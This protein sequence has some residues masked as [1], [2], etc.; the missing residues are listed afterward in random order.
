M[1]SARP[2]AATV[3][4][5]DQ[6]LEQTSVI[7]PTYNRAAFLVEALDSLFAQTLSPGEI[8]VI[9]DGST[10]DTQARLRAFGERIRYARKEN[11][12]KSDSLNIGLEMARHPLIWIMDDDDL[13]LP[14]TLERLTT[15]LA[16]RPAA[17]IAYGRYQRFRVDAKT[18]RRTFEDCGY[19]PD[20]A[21]KDLFLAT[22]EDFFVHH[23]GMLV[24]KSAYQAV[25][26]FSSAY[27]SE[28]YE[29][30]IRLARGH[31]S[32]Q[33][34]GPVFLQRQHDGVRAGGLAADR[35]MKRWVDE[36]A[37]LFR[38][39]RAALPLAA[40]APEA[41]EPLSPAATREALIRRGV[42]MARK[43]LWSEAHAD[44]TAA[45]NVADATGPLS[46]AE[47]DALR[48]ALFSKFG[49][50]ELLTDPSVSDGL[51]ALGAHGPVGKAIVGAFA[52]SLRWFIRTRLQK[53]RFG[54]ALAFARL[55]RRLAAAAR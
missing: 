15:A 40:Y 51:A 46:P 22:L 16:N 39:T 19:W 42:V 33:V 53:G 28:D 8:I 9:D 38:E 36:Q 4:A 12:G 35:R 1:S 25:G 26:P 30:L 10:D 23:P 7:V 49:V 48:R 14:D 6:A 18:G 44:F 11:S 52:R 34:D 41:S 2:L 43:K 47:Y 3:R 17:A 24:R 55:Q 13:A 32:V 21:D 54:E 45:S 29:M 37:A 27:V 50:E 31:D 20:I 5:S